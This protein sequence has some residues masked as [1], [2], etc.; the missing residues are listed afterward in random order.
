MTKRNNRV[1]RSSSRKSL[2]QQSLG[3]VLRSSK[4]AKITKTSS[5]SRLSSPSKGEISRGKKGTDNGGG[6]RSFSVGQDGNLVVVSEE[7]KV[8][9]IRRPTTSCRTENIAVK[10]LLLLRNAEGGRNADTVQKAAGNRNADARSGATPNR[11]STKSEHDDASGIGSILEQGGVAANATGSGLGGSGIG[12]EVA[13]SSPSDDDAHELDSVSD[14]GSSTETEEDDEG[15]GARK[16]KNAFQCP[17]CPTKLSQRH[18]LRR[19]IRSVHGD[20]KPFKCKH[21]NCDKAYRAKGDLTRH[22]RFV[23]K[24]ERPYTC[25]ECGTVFTRLQSL[26]SHRLNKK[27]C[28]RKKNKLQNKAS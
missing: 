11:V 18:R 22:V 7:G 6:K 16:K 14:E 21:E 8:S 23:H 28:N 15:K 26:H 3:P 4:S 5:R 9:V 24:S 19:H 17:H 1:T 27:A 20:G 2:P 13:R 10:A 12:A 25:T